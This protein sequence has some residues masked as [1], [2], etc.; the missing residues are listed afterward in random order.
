MKSKRNKTITLSNEQ[1]E[2]HLKRCF[3][4]SGS[5][6]FAE[7]ENKVIL[8]DTFEVAPL[9]EKGFADL[10]I[11]DP[12]YNIDKNFDDDKFKTRS[13]SEYREYTESWLKLALPLLKQTASVYVCCDWKSS[14]IIGDVL[15][16]YLTVKNRITWQREKGRGAK[17]NWKNSMEDIWFATVSDDYKFNLDAVKL[18]RRVIA[19]YRENNVPKDWEE[20]KS[21]NFRDTCPSN[22]W[23][24]ISV[25][26]WS[27]AEN[28]EHPTQKPEKLIAKLILASTDTNDTVFDLFL[29]SGTTAV[30]AKKLERRFVG[31]EKSKL[32][33]ALAQERLAKA[34]ENN[35]IQGYDDGVFWERNTYNK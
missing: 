21:G 26:F 29:G 22:F 6:S 3:T 27:M 14:L 10:L 30:T 12:P 23:D 5:A 28:T 2:N 7:F 1:I 4:I 17:R 16:K 20:T 32:Y 9:L 11:A 19:P 35:R 13:E 15:S 18:R 24:D 25:P 34:D 31:I 33:C 8:G